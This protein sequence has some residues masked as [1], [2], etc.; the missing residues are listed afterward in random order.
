MPESF[1]HRILFLMWTK[2]HITR[3]PCSQ[4]QTDLLEFD[5]WSYPLPYSAFPNLQVF[6]LDYWSYPLH[7]PTDKSSGFYSSFCLILLK[8]QVKEWSHSRAMALL[9]WCVVGELGHHRVLTNSIL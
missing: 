8:P 7:F 9:E 6:W 4:N 1:D 5:Y 2:F 3:L